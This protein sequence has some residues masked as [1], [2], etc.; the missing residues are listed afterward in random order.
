MKYLTFIL[1]ILVLSACD[2]NMEYDNFQKTENGEWS[3]EDKKVFKVSLEDSL[4]SYNVLINIRHTK[5]YPKSNLFLFVTAT[6]PAGQSIRD[7][8]EIQIA[9][10][11]GK[12]LGHGFGNIRLVSRIYRKNVRFIQKGEYTFT[13][14]QGMR[15]PR[16]PV[17]DVG[18]RIEKFVLIK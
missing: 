14:E 3:W 4:R 2:P 8:V 17:T 11:G 18:L 5:D 16:I 6:S 7:T 1:L 13:L 12:W 15:L 10:P 9:D